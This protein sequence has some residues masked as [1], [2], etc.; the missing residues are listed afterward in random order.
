[1]FGILKKKTSFL[2]IW[3]GTPEIH[4]HVL[5]GIDDGAKDVATSITL[6]KKYAALGCRQIIATPHTM[7]GIYDNTPSSI[8]RA[9]DSIKNDTD[10]VALS[11]SSEYILDDNFENLL[12]RKEILPLKDNFLLVELS[13][14]QPP[15]NLNEQ[16]FK[17][18][19]QG[20]HPIMAHP[21][22][23]A[24]YHNRFDTYAELKK[25]GSSLQLNALSLTP[26]YGASVQKVAF[27]LLKEGIY[28]YIGTDTH[29]IDHLDKIE[30]MT[31]PSKYETA[32]AAICRNTQQTFG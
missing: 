21:E 31:I 30:Q 12:E 4:C 16:L 28:D 11:Y 5:P 7:G 13:F 22:R 19:A 32:L 25:K 18:G 17:I 23:Y 8:E 6:L 3:R 26:H 1:M 27:Q 14:F 15:E 20:F 24:Y 10:Q 9:Y 29:R 2:D